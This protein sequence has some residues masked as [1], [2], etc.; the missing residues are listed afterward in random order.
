MGG[1]IG[2]V[3]NIEIFDRDTRA[4]ICSLPKQTSQQIL[5]ALTFKKRK[6]GKKFLSKPKK[7]KKWLQ[8][9]T[10]KRLKMNN[11]QIIIQNDSSF[12]KTKL[13]QIN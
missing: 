1:I 4:T 2:N 9:E 5:I 12:I 10:N 11:R 3:S 13:S 6:W 7:I 8:D